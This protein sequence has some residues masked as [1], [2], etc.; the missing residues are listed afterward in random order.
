[1]KKT[2]IVIV[3]LIVLI[4]MLTVSCGS[5]APAEPTPDLSV[6]KALVESRC[7]TCHGI[8]N[9]TNAK[10][11]REVWTTTVDRMVLSG[12]VLNDQ[13]KSDIVDYLAATFKPE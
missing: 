10:Y 2:T 12:A 13:Q 3:L 9:I 11:T 4:S 1:M 5:A 6:G 8:N 7:T